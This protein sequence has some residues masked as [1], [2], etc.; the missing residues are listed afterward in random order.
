MIIV[1]NPVFLVISVRCMRD[2]LLL[3]GS[4]EAMMQFQ[5]VLGM[6]SKI[7]GALSG[8]R[9]FLATGSP[10]KMMK[11][12]FYFTRKALFVLKICKFLS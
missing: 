5:I 11:N 6:I 3:S 9:Q 7:K 1:T 2:V 12:A 10:L 8:L 4:K